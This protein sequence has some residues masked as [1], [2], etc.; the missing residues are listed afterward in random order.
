MALPCTSDDSIELDQAASVL[1]DR[2][3]GVPALPEAL[4]TNPLF[5]AQQIASEGLGVHWEGTR[6]T[7]MR[8]SRLRAQVTRKTLLPMLAHISKGLLSSSSV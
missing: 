6:E 7:K 3:Q 4:A 8:R 2:L 1:L 5:V